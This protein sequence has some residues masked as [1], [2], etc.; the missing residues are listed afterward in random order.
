MAAKY[1]AVYLPA[2]NIRRLDSQTRLSPG[3]SAFPEVLLDEIDA[4]MAQDIVGRRR[5][6]K[7]LRRAESQQRA[8][9]GKFSR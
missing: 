6:K 4:A 7:E 5:V 2:L 9:A 3:N 1:S 8:L